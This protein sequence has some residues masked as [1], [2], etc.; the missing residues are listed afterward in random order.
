MLI[1]K[2]VLLMDSRPWEMRPPSWDCEI[3]A[4]TV[5]LTVVLWE[6]RGLVPTMGKVYRVVR[7]FHCVNLLLPYPNPQFGS[8]MVMPALFQWPSFLAAQVPRLSSLHFGIAVH[9][10]LSDFWTPL[11]RVVTEA[12]YELPHICWFKWKHKSAKP[13]WHIA[14]CSTTRIYSL[15]SQYVTHWAKILAHPAFLKNWEKSR[16]R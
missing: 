6:L 7:K 14:S 3:R 8:L 5:N 9:D 4:E 15:Y 2:S 13:L 12:L 1:G 10:S 16:N 11:L